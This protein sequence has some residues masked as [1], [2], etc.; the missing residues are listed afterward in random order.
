M[1]EYSLG[2]LTASNI[3]T[4]RYIYEDRV[5]IITDA[6][7]QLHHHRLAVDISSPDQMEIMHNEVTYPGTEDDIV[8]MI[9][10]PC[11]KA[12]RLLKI[13]RYLPFPIHIPLK[14]KADD[15]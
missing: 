14:T 13:Y 15:S 7:Q 1:A 10:V 8:L 12:T 11:I 9:H 3:R 4:T 6:I 2:L 5:T